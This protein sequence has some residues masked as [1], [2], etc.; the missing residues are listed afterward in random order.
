LQRLQGDQLLQ[1]LQ[2]ERRDSTTSHAISREEMRSP[3]ISRGEMRPRSVP[4]RQP[5]GGVSSGRKA[6]GPTR[7]P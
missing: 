3:A 2:G 6:R 5:P 1:G 4:P 7:N